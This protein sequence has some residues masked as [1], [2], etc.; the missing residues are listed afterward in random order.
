[1]GRIIVTN[2]E[3]PPKAR[4]PTTLTEVGIFTFKSFVAFMNTLTGR[5]VMLVGMMTVTRLKQLENAAS[6]ID[7]TVVGIETYLIGAKLE[8]ANLGILEY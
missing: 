1:M 3:Q 6:P 7:L 4:S 5:D 2:E 8:N